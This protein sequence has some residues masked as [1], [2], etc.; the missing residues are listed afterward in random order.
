MLPG[1]QQVGEL[2]IDHPRPVL[3][4]ELERGAG[5]LRGGVQAVRQVVLA[6]GH[7]DP[8]AIES[9]RR[10]PTTRPRSRGSRLLPPCTR[11]CSVCE[12][13]SRARRSLQ[14]DLVQEASDRGRARCCS[15]I[16]R[17]PPSICSI[18]SAG[19]SLRRARKPERTASASEPRGSCRTSDTRRGPRCARRRR[20]PGIRP[21]R[22]D[23]VRAV[24]TSWSLALFR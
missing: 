10:S 16:T 9:S 8:P 5:C 19:T 2:Q 1:T 23:R 15:P 13:V 4:P 24:V 17:V 6:A 22:G 11:R 7:P 12:T 18:D 3:A 21:C 14:L 20:R